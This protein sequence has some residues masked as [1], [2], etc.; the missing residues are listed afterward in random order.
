M[1]LFFYVSFFFATILYKWRRTLTTN[2]TNNKNKLSAMHTYRVIRHTCA[3]L[4]YTDTANMFSVAIFFF[5]GCLFEEEYH[6]H[7]FF[8]RLFY[9]LFLVVGKFFFV[10]F[11]IFAVFLALYV[12]SL[13]YTNMMKE[14]RKCI[15][16]FVLLL[17]LLWM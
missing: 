7:R 5:V 8:L 14:A 17:L 2:N 4:F 15:D 16:Y 1:V 10:C 3:T 12:L 11:F 13:C 6:H 9:F